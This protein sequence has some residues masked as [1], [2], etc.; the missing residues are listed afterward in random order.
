MMVVVILVLVYVNTFFFVMMC[1]WL[2]LEAHCVAS[3]AEMSLL[4]VLGSF[5]NLYVVAFFV[6]LF[7]EGFVFK[8]DR[9]LPHKV[10]D[11]RQI[12]YSEV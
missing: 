12:E 1:I 11:S 10:H 2:L 5:C 4:F 9:K 3:S 6:F 7:G 8:N